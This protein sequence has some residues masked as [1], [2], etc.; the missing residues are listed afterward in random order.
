MATSGGSPPANNKLSNETL[1]ADYRK[2]ETETQIRLVQKGSEFVANFENC[3]S[4][5]TNDTV[6]KYIFIDFETSDLPID[7]KLPTHENLKHYPHVLQSASLV[8]NAAGEIID[9]Y[10][11]IIKVPD[12]IYFHPSATKVNKLSAEICAENG[13]SINQFFRFLQMYAHPEV[14]LIAHNIK[15]DN[16][17]LKLE[18]KRNNIKLHKMKPFCTMLT[19][20]EDFWIPKAYGSG[21]KNPNLKELLNYSY[22]EGREVQIGIDT[23]DALVDVKI[24]ALCFFKRN[25]TKYCI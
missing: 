16:F 11:S 6:A 19:A 1:A 24:C 2:R 8:F 12:G 7:H 20:K 15:F 4:K 3:F 25:Y 14:F 17:M 21:F 23:H 9:S 10:S 13:K 18:A 22:F 5:A